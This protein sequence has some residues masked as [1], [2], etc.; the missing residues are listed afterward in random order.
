MTRPRN[1]KSML[2]CQRRG[3]VTLALL[4]LLA[5]GGEPEDRPAAPAAVDSVAADSAAAPGS[6]GGTDL[7]IRNTSL[8]LRPG[9]VQHVLY[10]R[11]REVSTRPGR[12]V[13]LDDP[14]SYEIRIDV[15]ET[16]MSWSSLTTLMNERVFADVEQISDVNV[17]PGEEDDEPGTIEIEG[18]LT[19]FPPVEF[20]IEGILE[21]TPDGNLRVA[22]ASIEAYEIGVGGLLGLFD[23]DAEDILPDMEE[24]GIRMEGDDM[25]LVLARV[26]PPPGARGAVTRVRVERDR[27][28][29]GF[30]SSEEARAGWRRSDANYLHHRHGTIKVGRMTM[31]DADML[32]LDQDPS[33]PFLYSVERVNEQHRAGF[34]KLQR[35]GGL[36]VHAPD[37]D[38]ME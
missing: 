32:V 24:Q 2:I 14:S 22:M 9:V 16:T 33:D 4:A 19:S 11:G 15:A 27:L 7:E 18:M 13:V 34:I 38:D 1:Y 21:P 23:V 29:I 28:V 17:E 31:E 26:M 6:D 36:V 12:P 30:G 5:C 8:I 10:L 37:L 25:V 3:A 20:E 35:D